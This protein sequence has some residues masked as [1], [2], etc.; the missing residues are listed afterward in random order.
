VLAIKGKYDDEEAEDHGR[1][2][3]GLPQRQIQLVEAQPAS[4]E[5][6]TSKSEAL[7]DDDNFEGVS[8]DLSLPVPPVSAPRPEDFVGAQPLFLR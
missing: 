8:P 1:K 5:D 7:K 4:V 3:T 6:V 2:R